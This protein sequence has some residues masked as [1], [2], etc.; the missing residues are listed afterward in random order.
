MN[1]QLQQ[2]ERLKEAARGPRGA[3]YHGQF[4][5]TE[6]GASR[7][8][9]FKEMEPNS[10]DDVWWES[11]RRLMGI[12]HP[13]M[14]PVLDVGVGPEGK[15]F[16]IRAHHEE[17]KALPLWLE[18]QHQ[19]TLGVGESVAMVLQLGQ[20]LSQCHRNGVTHRNLKPNNVLILD[21]DAPHDGSARFAAILADFGLPPTDA[22]VMY[23]APELLQGMNSSV[24]TDM[25]G[26]GMLLLVLVTGHNPLGGPLDH[27]ITRDRRLAME[28]DWDA[29]VARQIN[30]LPLFLRDTVTRCIHNN[31][32][33][34]HTNLS[35]MLQELRAS[36]YTSA[37]LATRT[38]SSVPAG[39]S[40]V[41][42]AAGGIDIR[43]GLL[44]T[45]TLSQ[46]GDRELLHFYLR[47]RDRFGAWQR[48]GVFFYN[49]TGRDEA[50]TFNSIRNAWAGAELSL[51]NAIAVP[52]KEDVFYTGDASTL[53]I[54]QPYF[55][56]RCGCC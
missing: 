32:R 26:L 25:Y 6:D 1:T 24:S 2:V 44:D 5:L 28:R 43:D 19:G 42:G 21:N 7:A 29:A 35:E 39:W 8:V 4:R 16:L 3:L 49:S 27:E 41:Q 15:P 46:R 22:A 31:P 36:L 12:H 34:R 40:S 50:Q 52:K 51:Y 9:M 37:G 14:S 23:T 48:S 17:A 47:H 38:L 20:A 10:V 13:S 56:M 55:P 45:P 30:V 54:L 11:Q 33:H 18:Q 53:P